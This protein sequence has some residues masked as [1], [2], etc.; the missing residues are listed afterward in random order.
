MDEQW[1]D[2]MPVLEND[3]IVGIISRESLEHLAQTRNELKS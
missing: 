2:Y 1:V 3:R